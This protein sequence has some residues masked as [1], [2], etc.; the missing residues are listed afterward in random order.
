MPFKW[1]SIAAETTPESHGGQF[2]F[3]PATPQYYRV[4]VKPPRQEGCGCMNAALGR[5]PVTG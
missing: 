3:C 1:V 2:G 5:S 4:V